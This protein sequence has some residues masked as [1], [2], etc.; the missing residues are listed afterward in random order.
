[1]KCGLIRN[2]IA[3]LS[4]LRSPTTYHPRAGNQEFQWCSSK[5]R[6]CRFRLSLGLRTG[7]A[8]GEGRWVSQLRQ[9]GRQRANSSFLGLFIP[10]RPLVN[11]MTL[12][13]VRES[14]CFLS[15]PIQVRPSG[16]TSLTQ[17]ETGLTRELAAP[18]PRRTD[19]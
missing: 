6:G 17:T 7:G 13:H 5:S 3:W 10:F 2:E 16:L 8:D 14:G 4:R 12:P 19:I 9:A 18:W 15:P 11:C 1:M